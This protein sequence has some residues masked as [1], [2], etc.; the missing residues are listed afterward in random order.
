MDKHA[1]MWPFCRWMLTTLHAV[2]ATA[3]AYALMGIANIGFAVAP[4]AVV[5]AVSTSATRVQNYGY[6]ALWN[7]AGA[8]AGPV[9]AGVIAGHFGYRTAFAFVWLLMIPSFVFAGALQ[10]A[11]TARRPAVALATVHTLAGGILRQRGVAAVMFIAFIVVCAQTLQQ[12]FYPLYLQ[13]VRLSPALI[14]IAI[15]TISLSSMLVRSLLSRGVDWFGYSWLLL[16]ALALA[17]LSLGITPL[18]RR[19][20]PLIFVSALMG[21]STG[22]TQP[23]AMSLLAE[24]VDAA[25]WGVAFG[26][27]QGVQRMGAILSPIAFGLIT[28]ASGVE[29]AFFLGGATLLAGALIVA[30]VSAQLRPAPN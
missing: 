26:I 17:A 22:F 7:S 11:P 30:S 6:Y 15:A 19:F 9:L 2:W 21:A 10:D 20:W 12:S 4:Q 14:G 3:V 25:L 1:Q 24:S 27:R 16:G 8:A 29:V 28:T 13:K 23:L 5:A 18:L